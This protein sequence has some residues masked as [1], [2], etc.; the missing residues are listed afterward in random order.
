MELLEDSYQNHLQHNPGKG[1]SF[2]IKR[3]SDE[4]FQCLIK[5]L[6]NSENE[7]NNSGSINDDFIKTLLLLVADFGIL[8]PT[9]FTWAR[10]ELISWQLNNAPKPI[11]ST[12]QKAYYSLVKGFRSWI[13]HSPGIGVDRETGEEY[14]WKDVINFDQSIRQKHRDI[15]LK[16]VQETSLI[17]ESLFFFQ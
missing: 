3:I 2:K 15:I 4:H 12:A 11:H 14:H 8:H 5:Y 9:R 16:A 13:G 1:F 6:R 17:K 10:S 7:V